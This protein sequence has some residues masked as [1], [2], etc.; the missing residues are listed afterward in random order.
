MNNE[1]IYCSD[2]KSLNIIINVHVSEGFTLCTVNNKY[3]KQ[4]CAVPYVINL[5]LSIDS[6]GIVIIGTFAS[7]R[8][9]QACLRDV[10]V[11]C[12]LVMFV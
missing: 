9:Q 4:N 10:T 12:I 7:A 11:Q 3:L 2:N 5:W 8:T 6:L 1:L